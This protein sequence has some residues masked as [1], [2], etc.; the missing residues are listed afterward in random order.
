MNP[1]SKTLSLLTHLTLLIAT[2]LLFGMPGA[3]AQSDSEELILE[4]VIV[5]ATKRAASIQELALSVSALQGSDLEDQA[6]FN[7][8]DYAESV[9]GLSFNGNEPG[10]SKLIVRGIS[11]DLSLIHI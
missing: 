3:F 5:T 10:N 2:F 4:E 11:T 6:A 9:P 7:F 1:L 8:A